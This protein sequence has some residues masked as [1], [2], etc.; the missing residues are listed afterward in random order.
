MKLRMFMSHIWNAWDLVAIA[1]FGVGAILRFIPDYLQDAHLVYTVNLVL[2]N[3]RILEI[4]SVNQY[5]GPYVKIIGKL[6]RKTSFFLCSASNMLIWASLE[7][8]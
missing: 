7:T 4:M 5:L 2:W 3:M 6:V 8:R 1:V